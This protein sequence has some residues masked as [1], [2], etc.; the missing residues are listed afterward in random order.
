[1]RNVV[2]HFTERI[3]V[4]IASLDGTLTTNYGGFPVFD[5]KKSF[6]LDV[7]SAKILMSLNS[8]SNDLNDYVFARPEAPLKRLWV[9][10]Q[11]EKLGV[12]GV[13]ASRRNV[14]FEIIGTASATPDGRIRIHTEKVK[15]LHLPVKGLLDLLGLDTAKLIDTEKIAGVSADK[16]DLLLDPEQ[17]LPAPHVHGQLKSIQVQGGWLVLVFGK[18]GQTGTSEALPSRCGARNY[19]IFRGGTVRFGK[20]TMNDTELELIDA[21]PSTPFDFSIDHY[22]EQLAAGYSKMTRDGGLCVY[23]PDFSKLKSG[24]LTPR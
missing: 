2:F 3:E 17:L 14:P 8:L 7:D 15:A 10:E 20:L 4:H 18:R 21:D 19:Q 16:G 13:L 6:D 22:R 5:D 1:M 11:G 23:M 24:S 12:K 9:W